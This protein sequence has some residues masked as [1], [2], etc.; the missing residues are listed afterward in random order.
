MSGA[1][2]TVAG[3]SSLP[4]GH[5][6]LGG[7]GAD[8]H[9]EPHQVGRRGQERAGSRETGVVDGGRQ[10]GP[11]TGISTESRVVEG[12]PIRDRF[13]RGVGR[14]IGHAQRL[15]DLRAHEREE[16]LARRRFDRRAHQDPAEGRIPV[17]RLRL[18]LQ[19]IILRNS[20]TPR[21]PAR[22]A[23]TACNPLHCGSA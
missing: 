5:R 9:P 21:T 23:R 17:L 16:R 10:L 4:P 14:R 18:E 1:C 3:C 6:S 2:L 11:G 7:G 20:A 12:R 22:S 15:E 19:R 13:G 8:R